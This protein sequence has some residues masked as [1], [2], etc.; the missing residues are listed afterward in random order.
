MVY[1]FNI[2]NNVCLSVSYISCIIK[3][4]QAAINAFIAESNARIANYE[5]ELKHWKSVIPFEHMTM[6]EFAECF[7]DKVFIC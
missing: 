5:A 7:P 4:Q 2:Q 3:I 1:Y 6:E